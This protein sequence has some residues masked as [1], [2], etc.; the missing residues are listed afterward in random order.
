MAIAGREVFV[1]DA[2]RTPVGRAH[3]EKGAYRD[4]HPAALLGRVYT[5]LLERTGV[6]SALVDRAIVGCVYQI[7]EQ[8]G[9]ITR[10]AWLQEGL[11]ES[12]GAATVDVR[13]GSGQ[14][15]VNLAAT[16]IASG[17]AELILAGGVEHM[18][19]VGFRVNEAAQETWGRAQ[20]PELLE[21]FDLVPQGISAELIARRWGVSRAEMDEFSLRSHRL[22]AAAARSGAFAR[23]IL[24]VETPAGIQASDQGIRADTSLEALAELRP[25]FIEDGTV[26]AG[27]SSQI[28]DGAA[29][30]LLGTGA[31]AARV[32]LRP[33]ARIVD[34]VLLG[35]DPVTMLT[36]PIPATTRILERN[37]LTI[38]DLDLIEINE[39]FASVVLAWERELAPEMAR[40]NVRGGAIAVGHPLGS[41]GARLVTSLVHQL[42]DLDGTLGLVTMCCAGG[43][44]IATLVER[45]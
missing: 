30:V 14:H 7:A 35:V 26:T 43:I 42:E 8:S 13:C 19:R 6:E 38:A 32:G 39:A 4:V 18:G 22:A 29:G 41:T 20:T 28:S 2:A 36:G 24:P 45:V 31:A 10:F 27:N 21:R 23:E 17:A 25:A 15:A 40:V 33:R 16:E 11:A 5:G 37:R 9:G 12:T 44:G 1:L 34:Q 3:P